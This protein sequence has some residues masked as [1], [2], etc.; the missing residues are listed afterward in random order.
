M[1]FSINITKR[2]RKRKLLSGQSVVHTRY[3]VNYG[4]RSSSSARR[5][6]NRG[7]AS[8]WSASPTDCM[9]TTARCRRWTKRSTIG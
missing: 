7:A 1:S 8:W 9:W 4:A 2:E 5:M 6:P 3:V